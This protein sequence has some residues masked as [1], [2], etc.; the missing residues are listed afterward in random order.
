MRYIFVL[1]SISSLVA[2]HRYEIS[3]RESSGECSSADSPS[4]N[5]LAIIALTR[6]FRET[7]RKRLNSGSVVPHVQP[8]DIYVIYLGVALHVEV[9]DRSDEVDWQEDLQQMIGYLQQLEKKWKIA[10]KHD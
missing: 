2:L 3:R 6:I 7:S 4:D 5:L 10:G 8:Y 1:I 9:T